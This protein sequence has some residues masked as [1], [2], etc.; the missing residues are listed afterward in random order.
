MWYVVTGVAC[1][2]AGAVLDYL[3]RSRVINTLQAQLDAAGQH[4]KS[5][6][7]KAKI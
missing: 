2:I 4:I 7:D 1:F 3:Y 5:L 6:V